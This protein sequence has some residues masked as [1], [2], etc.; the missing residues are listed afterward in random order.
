[1]NNKPNK[2]D[3]F[4]MILNQT[5]ADGRVVEAAPSLVSVSDNWQ[6]EH[7]EGQLAVDVLQT[8]KEI[9]V[10]STMA[11]A[12]TDEI[13][14]YVHNDLLTIRG[15]RQCPIE[16]IGELEYFHQECFWGKFSRTIV[17]PVEVKGELSRAEYKNGI[18]VIHIPKRQT[19]AKI[20][21]TI[22]EE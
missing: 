18:L 16:E 4:E 9:V 22:V 7:Q 11:G 5:G 2:T 19:D 1:M 3:V 13:E 6:A 10:I 17:L 12:L 14:V 15:E 8:D 21:I 20:P